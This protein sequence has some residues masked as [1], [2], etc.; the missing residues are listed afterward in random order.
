MFIDSSI[1]LIVL[2]SLK[3]VMICIECNAM[4]LIAVAKA[5]VVIID[6]A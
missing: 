4:A 2:W 5:P 1:L 6:C 3:V